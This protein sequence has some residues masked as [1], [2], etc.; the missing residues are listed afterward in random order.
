MD[1]SLFPPGTS[2]QQ[3]VKAT[4]RR[5]FEAK[6]RAKIPSICAGNGHAAA[7]AVHVQLP[8]PRFLLRPGTHNPRS[9][10]TPKSSAHLGCTAIYLATPRHDDGDTDLMEV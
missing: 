1:V 2:Q 8:G 4:E 3:N 6:T 7:E 9:S 5:H 10:D